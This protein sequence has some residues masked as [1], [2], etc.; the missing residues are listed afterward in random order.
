[1]DA[2]ARRFN[3]DAVRTI[4]LAFDQAWAMLGEAMDVASIDLPHARRYALA[5]RIVAKANE[6]M[7]DPNDLAADAFAFVHGSM[8]T[9]T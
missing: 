2:I 6:G 1:M 4:A 7:A 9:L 3:T 8:H 5:K